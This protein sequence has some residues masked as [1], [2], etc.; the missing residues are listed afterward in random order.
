MHTSH[1]DTLDVQ[2]QAA[3][4]EV[5]N[6]YNAVAR[7]LDALSHFFY[8][9]KPVAAE[10]S[11][12]VLAT[13]RALPAL[14]MEDITPFSQNSSATAAAPEELL[15]H[16]R[17]KRV[18][19]LTSA[20]LTREDR[21]KL[22]RHKKEVKK[23]ERAEQEKDTSVKNLRKQANKKLDEELRTDKRV[24]MSESASSKRHEDSNQYSKSSAF[25]SKLQED[26]QKQIKSTAAKV[27]EKRR[28]EGVEDQRP[29]ASF[30]L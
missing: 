10:A 26:T 6:L 27:G 7:E 29:A 2:T 15:E 28:R 23:V 12:K 20:E 18:T 16:K 8:S 13:Q 11:A 3:R 21:K 17:G 24:V 22:R 14:E 1:E 19:L 9:P 4:E 5:M 25:F 30:K